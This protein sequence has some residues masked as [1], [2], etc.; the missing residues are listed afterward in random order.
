MHSAISFGDTI[1]NPTADDI[2]GS[3]FLYPVDLDEDNDFV[4]VAVDNCP[5][6]ANPDQL[7]ADNDGIGNAC[8]ADDDNDGVLDGVDNCP[9]TSNPA[10]TNTDGT[11]LGDTSDPATA[12]D[13]TSRAWVWMATRDPDS[14]AT[15][16]ARR[17]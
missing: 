17:S 16:T 12:T 14:L 5:L 11:A 8:D 1:I 15:R 6:T 9:L 13:G 3:N 4:L 2:A 10:Q 7:D